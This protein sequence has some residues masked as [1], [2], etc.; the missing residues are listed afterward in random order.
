MHDNTILISAQKIFIL[1]TWTLQDHWS[2][3]TEVQ[4]LEDNEPIFIQH[5]IYYKQSLPDCANLQRADAEPYCYK[6]Q[7]TDLC[8][9]DCCMRIS[10]EA[11]A[12]T[13]RW[14]CL[15]AGRWKRRFSWDWSVTYL[16]SLSLRRLSAGVHEVS[17]CWAAVSSSVNLVLLEPRASGRVAQR[18]SGNTAMGT[19]ELD[20]EWRSTLVSAVWSS[21]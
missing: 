3:G 7:L 13:G 9:M 12:E 14:R 15:C 1:T 19:Q 18:R 5:K 20:S 2:Q 10:V 16:H 4:I 11:E 21:S 8:R 6:K 17:C